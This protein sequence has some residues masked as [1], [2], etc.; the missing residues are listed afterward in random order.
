MDRITLIAHFSLAGA[1]LQLLRGTRGSFAQMWQLDPLSNGTSA[2]GSLTAAEA[3]R[4]LGG[5]AAMWSE[6]VDATNVDTSI[7]PRSCAVAERLWSAYP[8]PPYPQTSG[9]PEVSIDVATRLEAQR[10][11]MVRRGIAAGPHR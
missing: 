2:V 3:K 11:R 6:S 9:L 1:P 4:F 10:C 8:A 7:W 5:E